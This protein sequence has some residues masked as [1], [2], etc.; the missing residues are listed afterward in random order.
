MKIGQSL[1]LLSYILGGIP[2][3]AQA[4]Q[5][6]PQILEKTEMETDVTMVEVAPR[7][8]TTIR[9]PEAVNSVVVGDPEAFLVEHS[10]REPKLVFVKTITTKP[11]KTNLLIS[12][13][14]GRDTNLMLVTHGERSTTERPKVDVLLK[15]ERAGS[16]MVEP[17]A[18]AFAQV[19]Q[20]VLWSKVADPA[21]S[22]VPSPVSPSAVGS[23]SLPT[24]SA[25]NQMDKL[26]E[27]QEQSPLPPLYGEHVGTPSEN[28]DRIRAGVGRVMD[29]GGQVVVLF[30]VVNPTSHAIL[31]MPPQ[32]QLGGKRTSGKLIHHKRWVSSDQLAVL[33]FRLS[34]RRLGPGERADG[35]LLFERPPYKQSNET[36]LLQVAEAGAVDRPALAPLGFGINTSSEEHHGK[37]K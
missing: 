20:T 8:V 33:D 35:V 11:A 36:L 26:L 32:V 4:P 15:Y 2:A 30:S 16:F 7:F 23:S 14:A 19:G 22:P 24:S 3:F 6:E 13:V 10:E 5:I 27:Q 31:V 34:R 28:G 21:S 29:E 25:G 37:G 12:T 17:A 9:L 18:F 1:W